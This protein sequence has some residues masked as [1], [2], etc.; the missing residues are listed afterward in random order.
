MNI[1]LPWPVTLGLALFVF[2]MIALCAT[3]AWTA[4]SYILA[5]PLTVIFVAACWALIAL[6]ERWG[7][8]T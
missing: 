4:K 6:F 5:V 7:P 3:W 2:I 8:T 1:N